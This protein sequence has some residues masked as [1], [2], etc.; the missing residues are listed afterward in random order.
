[1]SVRAH[2][3]G[4]E[5]DLILA[6]DTRHSQKLLNHYA[7]RTPLLSLHEHNEQQRIDELLARLHGG[8]NRWH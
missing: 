3:A 1:M 2:N 6:E 8:R 7:I 4:Q 5:A